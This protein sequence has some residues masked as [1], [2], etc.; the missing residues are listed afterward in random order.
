MTIWSELEFYSVRT[1]ECVTVVAIDWPAIDP[2]SHPSVS[3]LRPVG[4][5]D[6]LNPSI[7]KSALAPQ[8]AYTL[9]SI[10][11]R[12]LTAIHVPISS[13]VLPTRKRFDDV[14][15]SVISYIE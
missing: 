10:T 2:N 13:A 9:G 14:E 7:A 11:G 12:S 3:I 15:V 5:D 1:L 8:H 4:I 6:H